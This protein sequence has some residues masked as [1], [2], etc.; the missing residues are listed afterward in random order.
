[1]STGMGWKQDDFWGLQGGEEYDQEKNVCPYNI[2]HY[3]SYWHFKLTMKSLSF[4][5][6]TQLTYLD[7]YWQVQQ[8]LQAFNNKTRLAS[9]LALGCYVNWA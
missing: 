4:T 3:M 1:M 8:M 5:N 9:L 2:K 7:K 6:A